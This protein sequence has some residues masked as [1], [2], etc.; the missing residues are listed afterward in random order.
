MMKFLSVF[1]MLCSGAGFAATTVY[2]TV[3]DKGVVSFSDKSPEEGEA[4]VLQINTATPQPDGE[5]LANL[6]AMRETTDRMAA[7]RR[8][9]EKHRAE[10]RDIAARKQ[11][12][13]ATPPVYTQ[14]YPYPVY[15]RNPVRP[16]RP[17]YHPGYGPKPVHPI[18]RPPLR[19][20]SG[21]FS[22]TNSQLMR[23]IV[24]SRH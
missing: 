22:S 5:T 18:V 16:G 20:G 10:L 8:E 17:P 24:S 23:P 2:K 7:D 13:Q 9:R 3:D 14:Y 11:A 12:Y 4:E 21:T 19:T 1:L 6:E 15:S